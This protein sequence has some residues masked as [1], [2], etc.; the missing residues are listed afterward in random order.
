M[1]LCNAIANTGEVPVKRSEE[2][3]SLSTSNEA[4]IT[5]SSTDTKT[6]AAVPVN[7]Y[8]PIQRY[9]SVIPHLN[10]SSG[11]K[12]ALPSHKTKRVTKQSDNTASVNQVL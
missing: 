5:A 9:P 12:Y 4:S 8:D 3:T 11:D 7:F 1:S 10:T 6:P 2:S